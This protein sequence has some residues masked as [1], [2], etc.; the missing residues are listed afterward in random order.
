L[1]RAGHEIVLI[2]RDEF[3][4]GH[5][6]GEAAQKSFRAGAPHLVQPHII[7]PRC[8]ELLAQTLPDVYANL[9]ASGAV[10]APTE[11]QMPPSLSDKSSF[12]GDERLTSL[13]TRRST[14]DWILRRAVSNER[15]V[16]VDDKTQVSHLVGKPGNIPHVTGIRTGKGTIDA[17]LMID[18]GGY[19]T[20]IDQWI[21]QLGGTRPKIERAECGIAYFS[22]HYCRR[23]D[24]VVQWPPTTRMLF[25]LD[26]FTVGLWSGDNHTVQIAIAPLAVDHRFKAVLH[27]DVFTS[28]LRTVP[29]IAAQLDSLDPISNV[30]AM[31]SVQNTLR[32][33]VV[34]GAPL[35]TGLHAVGD[36][37]CTTNP[38]LGRG[39]TFAI[40]EALQLVKLISSSQGDAERYLAYDNWISDWV[41]PF[42]ADQVSIDG[43]RLVELRHHVLGDPAPPPATS[44]ARISFSELRLAA[45][46][47]PVAYRAFWRLY[48]M[49]QKPEDIYSD[50]AVVECVRRVLKT[51][52]GFP[53][54]N[55]PGREQLLAALKP[56]KS[57]DSAQRSERFV[58]RFD[59]SA[60]QAENKS[61]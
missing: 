26:E 1:A 10:E 34:D 56:Q 9:L 28:V 35:V 39:L 27:A 51:P 41:A 24:R 37:V 42:Y 30:F 54:A 29:A 45:M 61:A 57:G 5:T 44:E 48:G 14:L 17:D 36:S 6:P 43:V 18:A 15:R 20:Q 59:V 7:L 53:S 23:K 8:R 60:P 55:Q 22:C 33:L 58:S 50:P 2:E 11:T 13:M 12:P 47:D 38:T 16:R 25:A 49:L 4:I 46:F 19:R 40:T 32:R 3:N 31:G 21:E 52:R